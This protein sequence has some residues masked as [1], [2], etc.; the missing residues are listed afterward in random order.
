MPAA[1]SPG[2]DA[3]AELE[4]LSK[5]ALHARYEAVA[6]RKVEG[7]W[8]RGFVVNK[9]L[10]KEQQVRTLSFALTPAFLPVC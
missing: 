5:E 7:G 8:N 9:I 10:Q 2:G 6:G 4:A 1:G 3:R